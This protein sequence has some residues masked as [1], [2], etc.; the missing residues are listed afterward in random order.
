M[1][2]LYWVLALNPADDSIRL[3][4][5]NYKIQNPSAL[6]W[7]AHAALIYFAW[8]FY[9]SSKNK[10]RHGFRSSVTTGLLSNQD[11]SICKALKKNAKDDYITKHMEAF[12]KEREECAQKYKIESYNKECLS[13]TPT[14]LMYEGEKL[15]LEYQAQYERGFDGD[16]YFNNYKVY[17]ERHQWL[18]FKFVRLVRFILGKEDSPDYVIPWVLFLLAVTTS[19]FSYFGV[20]ALNILS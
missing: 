8:R 7:V 6:F 16:V 15:C 1:F 9:L 3:S 14:N 13:V 4:I 18:W 11:S 12:Q 2:V 17:Y 20:T 5:I 19:V 10:I